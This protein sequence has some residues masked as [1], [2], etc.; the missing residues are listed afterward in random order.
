MEKRGT[1]LAAPPEGFFV[2]GSDGP[3]KDGEVE[4]ASAWGKAI[5]AA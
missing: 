2:K 4:R 3:L 1:P 5:G